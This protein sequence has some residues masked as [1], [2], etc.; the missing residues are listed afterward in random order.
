MD[1]DKLL[2]SKTRS[3]LMNADIIK[4]DNTHRLVLDISRLR[5]MT[6]DEIDG[7]RHVGKVTGEK[8]KSFRDS[9]KWL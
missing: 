3:A 2:R 4:Y 9:L 6:D 5:S 1:K 8:I 7:M